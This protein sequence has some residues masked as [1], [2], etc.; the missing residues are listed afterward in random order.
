[1][2]SASCPVSPRPSAVMAAQRASTSRHRCWPS[3]FRRTI[4]RA[5]RIGQLLASIPIFPK[6]RWSIWRASPA[7]Q[8]KF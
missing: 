6:L 2:G 8:Q 5:K 4:A 7:R 3:R 1:M